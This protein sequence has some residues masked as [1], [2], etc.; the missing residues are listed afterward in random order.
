MEIEFNRIINHEKC[1]VSQVFIDGEHF[2]FGMEDP[3]KDVK[4][5]GVTRIP[6]GRYRVEYRI[7]PEPS[8][9]TA[10]Y[11]KKYSWFNDHLMLQDVANFQ[12][13]YIHIGNT[14]K[15]TDGCLLV[16]ADVAED[17]FYGFRIGRSTDKF[18]Q[19]YQMAAQEISIG[20]KVFITVNEI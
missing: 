19:L 11:R 12:Y 18:Q 10:H 20:K 4:V 15:D 8:P 9:K 13:V 17:N 5:R 6:A 7:T 1:T 16:G 14:H 3:H 2:G